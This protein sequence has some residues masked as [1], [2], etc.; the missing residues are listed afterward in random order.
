M[1]KGRRPN[2]DDRGFARGVST[3]DG[4]EVKDGRREGGGGQSSGPER[5]LRGRGVKQS[6]GN[7]GGLEDGGW[8][9]AR[10]V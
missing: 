9:A 3:E 2:E 5:V 7:S 8:D 4:R 10:W 1:G 6:R